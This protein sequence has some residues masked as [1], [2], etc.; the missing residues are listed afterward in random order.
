MISGYLGFVSGALLVINPV[1]STGG[2]SGGVPEVQSYLD[3]MFFGNVG[4]KRRP[5]ELPS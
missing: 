5:D 4:A 3:R 2:F 1:Q